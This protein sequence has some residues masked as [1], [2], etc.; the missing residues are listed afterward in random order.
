[1]RLIFGVTSAAEVYQR[2]LQQVLQG[3][4]GCKNIPDD[5]VVY[6]HT[7]AE[8]N[9]L[10]KVLERLFEN[11]LTLNREK[12][13]F[14]KTELR[15]M[16]HILTSDGVKPDTDK[17]KTIQQT[18]APTTPK[19]IRSFLGLVQYCAKFIKDYAT[20]SEPLRQLTRKNAKW[21]R[22]ENHQKSFEILRNSLLNHDVLAYFK[23]ER[24]VKIIVDA[25]PVGL[26]AILV[27]EQPDK[28]YRPISYARRTLSQPERNYS[29][30]ER[31]ALGVFWGIERFKMY[32]QGG[33]FIVITDHKPLE[34]IYNS[35][36]HNPPPRIQ[37]WLMKLQPDVFTVKYEPGANNAADLLSRSPVESTK[38][39]RESVADE[40]I[41]FV[42][43]H[44]IPKAITYEEVVNKTKSDEELQK[45][46]ASIKSNRWD[47]TDP[48]I[49]PF[50]QQRHNLT[51]SKDIILKQNNLV[52]PHCLRTQILEIAHEGHQSVVKCKQHLRE[53]VWWPGMDKDTEK[54]IS[55][56]HACQIT[57][58]PPSPPPVKMTKSPSDPWEKV[59][60]DI[61]GSFPT[62]EYLFVIIVYYSRFPIV[63]IMRSITTKDILCTLITLGNHKRQWSTVYLC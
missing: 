58:Q 62:W 30:T 47:K 37:R 59:G 28:S 56:C 9:N 60:I 7:E 35:K 32:L 21:E 19:E 33:E 5:I 27:Q 38:Q 1:M 55:S 61:C 13:K 20:L 2:V 11:N 36:T 57:S 6:D 22:N 46:H 24:P 34:V 44:S 48:N 39:E 53:K 50:Y 17:I 52:V 23:T 16:G 49:L 3:L 18:Q 40:Y 45:V 63:E 42:T 26:G 54:L 43:M 25:S 15:F 41:S 31:E 4:E 51:T 10:S 12:C 14:G 29:Q 8:H